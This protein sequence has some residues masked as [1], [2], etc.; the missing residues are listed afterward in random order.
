MKIALFSRL[1]SFLLLMLASL[2]CGTLYWQAKQQIRWEQQQN[3]YQHIQDQI[4]IT[5]QRLVAEYLRSG[6]STH[7]TNAAR[8]LKQLES[9]LQQFPTKLTTAPLKAMQTLREKMQGDYLS[10]GKLSG[11]TSQL[12]MHAENEMNDAL[13]QIQKQALKSTQTEH[14][15]YLQLSS[16]MLSSMLKIAQLRE[17]LLTN[18]S[19]ALQQSLQFELNYL[20]EQLSKINA[21]PKL[22][23]LQT[24]TAQDELTLTPSAPEYPL[25]EPLST[26][27][28]VLV[29][30]PK[31]ISNTNQLLQQQQQMKTQLQTDFAQLEQQIHQIGQQLG[32]EQQKNRHTAII[33][34]AALAAIL[35]LYAI[36]AWLFQQRMVVKRLQRLQRAFHE[37]ASSG[38]MEQIPVVNANSEL[39]AIAHSFNLLL[40]QLHADQQRKAQQLEHITDQLHSMVSEVEQMERNATQAQSTIEQ[41]H[42][43]LQQLQDLAN[44]VELAASTISD[45][46][47]ANDQVMQQSQQV[48]GALHAATSTTRSQSDDCQQALH[49]WQ[50]AM[51]DATRIVDA[52]SHIAEQTNLLALNA[53]IEAARAGEHGRGFAV[54][55]DEVRSLSGHT[56]KSLTQIMSIFQQLKQASNQ[57]GDSISDIANATIH[58]SEQVNAL[59]ENAQQVRT[60]LEHSAQMAEQGNQHAQEQVQ[61]LSSFGA[62]M[63]EMQQQSSHVA[64]L[65]LQVAQRIAA[66]ASSITDTL[67]A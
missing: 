34:L 25:D 1:S 59:A 21:L 62:L 58:Q 22:S 63:A 38:Q 29:R 31:E 65:S 10:A 27:N 33:T 24:S 61:Q 60:T 64:E 37:L 2:L 56:Q 49:S 41:G 17:Q 43:T 67:K 4:S 30:Y 19:S 46:G 45:L 26:L 57:L 9:A 39:G 36:G 20:N 11:N 51:D 53:A 40:A 52:I 54:V 42:T 32:E 12:L 50:K 6:N 15:Q 23:D 55:A 8:Q 13:R 48:V 44:Q 3:D 16:E 18:T 5:T 35:V 28:S 47:A 66:Q 7:L 14:D